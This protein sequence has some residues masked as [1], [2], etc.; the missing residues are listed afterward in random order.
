MDPLARHLLAAPEVPA[1]LSTPVNKACA[2]AVSDLRRKKADRASWCATSRLR[3]W[4]SI[5]SCWLPSRTC[6]LQMPPDAGSF[7]DPPLN[8]NKGPQPPTSQVRPLPNN[9]CNKVC[10]CS[11]PQSHAA[12]TAAAGSIF[13]NFILVASITM[14]SGLRT[15]AGL[16]AL[17]GTSAFLQPLSLP[18]TRV[19]PRPMNTLACGRSYRTRM[20][21]RSVLASCTFVVWYTGIVMNGWAI[22]FACNFRGWWGWGCCTPFSELTEVDC[23]YLAR[24][25]GGGGTLVLIQGTS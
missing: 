11:T 9:L 23:A 24:C 13:A 6:L 21:V 5:I 18:S 1:E 4:G 16:A 14:A 8:P 19:A 20:T 12:A 7:L 25:G 17:A 10:A 22:D 2:V 3:G 15:F